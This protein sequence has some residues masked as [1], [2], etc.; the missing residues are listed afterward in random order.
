MSIKN[1]V[2]IAIEKQ[3]SDIHLIPGYP[4]V[5]RIDHK[6]V[7]LKDFPI[8]DKEETFQLLTSLLNEEQ[9]EV[10]FTNKE[11]D[12][13]YEY[14][15]YRL[16]VNMYYTKGALAGSFR[17]IPLKIKSIAELNL[18]PLIEQFVDL[19]QGLVL[20]TGHNSQGKSTTLA[21]IIN[22]INKKYS[23]HIITIEDPIEYVYPSGKSIISQREIHYDTHSWN[24]ALKSVLRQDPDVILI[25]EMRDYES[26]STTLTIAEAGNLVFSTLHTTSASESINR[27][28]DMFPPEEQ[29][30]ARSQ[31]SSVLKA[32]IS[33]HLVPKLD[34]LGRIPAVE[35]LLNIPAVS[36]IIREGNI[37]MLDAVLMTSEDKGLQLL[38]KDLIRLYKKGEISKETVLSYSIRPDLVG[39]LL[40]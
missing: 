14:R 36:S 28:I 21:A 16:R 30:Q 10:F 8:L 31:L 19:N 9:K 1:I 5:V 26:V 35:I 39:K 22:E 23:K 29:I 25:G 20:I 12:F 17:L 13:G 32:V 3:T 33:Q 34:G 40:S 6:L 4:P 18:P 2:D 37:H 24:R 11:I 15:D 27:I 38:E 7:P